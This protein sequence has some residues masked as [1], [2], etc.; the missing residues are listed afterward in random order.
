MP[1][2][3]SGNKRKIV[4]VIF[5]QD[6]RRIFSISESGQMLFW[7]WSDER[8][9]ESEAVLNFQTH[10]TGKRLKTGPNPNEYKPTEQD[11]SLYTP[12]E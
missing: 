8:S 4:K 1:F 9:K 11:T 5:S 3:F 10:K 12:L 2:T 6:D 7:R